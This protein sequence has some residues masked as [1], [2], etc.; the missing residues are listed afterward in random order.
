MAWLSI[1]RRFCLA[2]VFLNH[3]HIAQSPELAAE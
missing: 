2:A 3:R 1:R